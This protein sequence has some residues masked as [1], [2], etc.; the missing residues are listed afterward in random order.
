MYWYSPFRQRRVGKGAKAELPMQWFAVE[1]RVD[2]MAQ[3]V[4]CFPKRKATF[5]EWIYCRAAVAAAVVVVDDD[6][7]DDVDWC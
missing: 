5:V 4:V 7:D 1:E 6:D 2:V 3:R